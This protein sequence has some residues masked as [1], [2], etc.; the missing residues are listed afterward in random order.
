MSDARLDLSQIDQIKQ[1]KARYFR[2]LD[3]KQWERWR[4]Q[5]TEDFVLVHRANRPEPVRG[6]DA[7][8]ALVSASLADAITVHHGHM[9][10]IEILEGG[11]ARGIWAMYD[12]LLF[13]LADGTG[14]AV[15]EG[16]GHYLEQYVKEPD[17]RWRIA[18][19]ELQRLYLST[20]DHQRNVD[21]SAFWG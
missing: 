5:F 13:P 15:Y 8:V 6:R 2:Y 17:G 7:M 4:E 20:T 21:P 18:H 3:T 16:Y 12:R 10:E 9:P 11:R 14:R 19:I 1:L